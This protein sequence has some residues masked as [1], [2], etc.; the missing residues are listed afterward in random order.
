MGGR[1]K[2]KLNARSSRF[3][4]ITVLSGHIADSRN[5]SSGAVEIERMELGADE[6]R[7]W[8]GEAVITLLTRPL[9]SPP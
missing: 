2:S 5:E 6:L 8:R 9:G 7:Q 4:D 3:V 1:R